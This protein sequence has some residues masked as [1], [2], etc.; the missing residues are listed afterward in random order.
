M[1]IDPTALLTVKALRDHLWES[2]GLFRN[3]ISNQKDYVLALLFF[4]R[5]CDRYAE[6]TAAA[7]GPVELR[8]NHRALRSSCRAGRATPGSKG[9]SMSGATGSRASYSGSGPSGSANRASGW[10]A[11]AWFGWTFRRYPYVHT[12]SSP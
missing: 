12:T 2:E 10:I 5:A 8:G 7:H 4:K 3:K 9:S 11:R 1:P 6:E